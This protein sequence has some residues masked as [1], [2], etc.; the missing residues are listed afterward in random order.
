MA[1]K[2]PDKLAD[3]A[4]HESIMNALNFYADNEYPQFKET[5]SFTKITRDWFNAVNVK[6]IDYDSKLLDER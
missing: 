2:I 4:F 5:A 6:S 1:H 3:V